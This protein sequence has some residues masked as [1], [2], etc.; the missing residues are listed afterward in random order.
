LRLKLHS[1][2]FVLKL[3]F[4]DCGPSLARVGLGFVT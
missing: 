2:D 3:Q 1:L 4:E